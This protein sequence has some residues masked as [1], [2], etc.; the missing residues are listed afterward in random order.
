MGK[1]IVSS[2][3]TTVL[4]LAFV[5][6][7][8]VTRGDERESRAPL[9]VST[10]PVYWSMALWMVVLAV[11][12][13]AAP[14]YFFGPTWHYFNQLPH[15]GF[16]MGL[17]CLWLGG[18]QVIALLKHWGRGKLGFLFFL[19]GFVFWTSGLLIAAA[20]LIGKQGLLEAPFMLYAGAHNFLHSAILMSESRKESEPSTKGRHAR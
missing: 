2:L 13:M 18:V 12:L 15:N 19:D 7:A 8:I 6:L 3:A 14:D 11:F 10:T 5:P 20:G 17:C 1:R 9:M 16:W 4:A